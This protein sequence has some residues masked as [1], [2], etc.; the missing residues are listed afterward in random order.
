MF[1]ITNLEIPQKSLPEI[2]PSTASSQNLSLSSDLIGAP[3]IFGNDR[4]DLPA[5]QFLKAFQRCIT[6]NPSYMSDHNFRLAY[7]GSKLRGSPQDWFSTLE[8]RQDLSLT[9]WDDFCAIFKQ[10]F[11]ISRSQWQ[12]RLEM[13]DIM[14]GTRSVSDYT[15]HFRS[16]A[17]K[18]P[19]YGDEALL[20]QYY[21]GL[22]P[23]VQTYLGSLA[24]I[25]ESSAEIIDICLEFGG[26]APIIRSPP[27]KRNLSSF[28]SNYRIVESENKNPHYPPP[29]TNDRS[30]STNERKYRTDNNLCLYCGDAG[31]MISNCPRSRHQ[32][33]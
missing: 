27:V 26:R 30:L 12:I 29:P 21:I 17:N 9:T 1:E 6:L 32:K 23:S 14:Q 20:T 5:S 25:P 4:K 7:F 11:Q 28:P 31:H 19:G 13:H 2:F 10:Q 8:E 22:H 18:L 15:S 33:N 24:L 16:L 3:P